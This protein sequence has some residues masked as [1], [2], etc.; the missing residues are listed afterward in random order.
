MKGL[1]DRFMSA[2]NRR[3]ELAIARIENM[4]LGVQDLTAR[5]EGRFI[6]LSGVAPSREVASRVIELFSQYVEF[7][8]ILNAIQI[9]EPSPSDNGA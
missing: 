5:I 4:D 3:V 2:V 9:A 7:E 6:K 1:F 8:N